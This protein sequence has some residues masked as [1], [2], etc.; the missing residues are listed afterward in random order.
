VVDDP[1]VFPP[2]LELDEELDDEELDDEELDESE[3]DPESLL[4][5]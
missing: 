4:L 1:E 2:D 5:S 3:S